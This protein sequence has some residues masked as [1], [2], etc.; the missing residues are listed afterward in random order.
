MN[1]RDGYLCYSKR[2]LTVLTQWKK[3][4]PISFGE[5]GRIIR[6]KMFI[7]NWTITLYYH[8]HHRRLWSWI[9]TDIRN[10]NR[11]IA[12]F[13][14]IVILVFFALVSQ[15]WLVFCIDDFPKM[16]PLIL[17]VSEKTG[18]PTVPEA[19]RAKTCKTFYVAVLFLHGC[20]G[21]FKSCVINLKVTSAQMSSVFGFFF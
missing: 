16:S 1:W 3:K 20:N 9:S 12:F 10:R 11:K 13:S 21:M 17:S 8:F 14:D 5:S 19:W 6:I 15:N 4:Q 7:C 18:S 2:F